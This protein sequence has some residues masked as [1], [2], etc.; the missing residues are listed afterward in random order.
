MARNALIEAL[1]GDDAEGLE[2]GLD[3]RWVLSQSGARVDT[4]GDVWLVS[5]QVKINWRRFPLKNGILLSATRE[6]LKNLIRTRSPDYADTQ[7]DNLRRLFEVA[8]SSGSEIESPATFDEA[9]FANIKYRLSKLYPEGTAAN[10]LDAYRRWFL[11]GA[12]QEFEGFD[13][14]CA[15]FL[16]GQVIGGNA[17]GQ[18]VLSQDPNEGPL[19]FAETTA[20]QG[21]MLSMLQTSTELSDELLVTWLCMSFG[22]YPK[23]MAFL[24]EEDLVRTDLPDGA[25]RYELRI[26]R[27]KKRGVNPRDEFH[28]RPVDTRIGELFERKIR[29]NEAARWAAL[30]GHDARRFQRPMFPAATLNK[31]L[32]G[33]AFEAHAMRSRLPWFSARLRLFVTQAE[34]KAEDET[35]LNVTTRRLRY[36][37]ATRLV[38]EGASPAELADAL[39]HTDLQHVM[40]YFNSRSDAV[41]SLN[42]ALALKLAPIAQLFMGTLIGS[43]SE[44]LRSKDPASRIHF[45]D[46]ATRKLKTV[47]SCGKFSFCGLNAHLACYT[48]FKFEPWLEGPHEK[49]LDRLLLERNDLLKRGTDLKIVQANDLTIF[50]VAEVVIRCWACMQADST[51]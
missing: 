30:M 6:H 38:R 37:F 42:K 22:I 12:D 10:T 27:L 18:A 28:T 23:A 4:S 3:Q 36:T 29:E 46:P 26:P 8:K 43:E 47:G 48:C 35:P 14:E 17:K 34:L 51:T 45:A 41:I 25:V 49:V 19:R 32:V 13:Q 5:A 11:F 31:R 24:N 2:G 15:T 44:A 33:T 7:F 21:R 1:I 39:D 16:E 9:F 20:L 50:A 40:V